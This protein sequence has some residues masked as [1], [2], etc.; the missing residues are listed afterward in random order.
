LR[1]FENVASTICN[2]YMWSYHPP[3]TGRNLGGEPT[4][5]TFEIAGKFEKWLADIR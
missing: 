1:K 4:L 5:N 3:P 2:S